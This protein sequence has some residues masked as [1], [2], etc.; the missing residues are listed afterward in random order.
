[1]TRFKMDH[2][3]TERLLRTADAEQ[4]ASEAHGTL[5]GLLC[6]GVS[7]WQ[8]VLLPD[9]AP[10]DAA[11]EQMEALRRH[12]SRELQQRQMPLH[13]LLPDDAQPAIERATAIRDWTQGFLFG[14]GLGGERK[15]SFFEG[16]AG[17]AL[18]DFAEIARMDLSDFEENQAAEEALMQLQEYLWVAVSLIWHET[19]NDTE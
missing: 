5:A 12:T 6:A 8:P 4:S 7:E 1:M 13:L 19:Q 16:E 18:R 14:F 10:D 9:A 3:E 15:A 2:A 17:E 11:V